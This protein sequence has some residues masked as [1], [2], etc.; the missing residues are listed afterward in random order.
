MIILLIMPFKV[1][2]SV[3]IKVGGY[4][5]SYEDTVAWARRRY[6]GIDIYDENLIPYIAKRH[7]RKLGGEMTILSAYQGGEVWCLFLMHY[8]DDPNAVRGSYEKF[9]ED[10][11][12]IRFKH[13]AF[14]HQEDF[15]KAKFVTI[16][17][18]FTPR[19]Y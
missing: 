3:M 6:P 10:E 13:N 15:E 7:N 2:A 9:E 4:I 1:T 5:L 17:D 8:K 19:E 11:G 14:T 16:V 18:P 12:C